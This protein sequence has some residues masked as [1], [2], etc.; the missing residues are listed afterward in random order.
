MAVPGLR[1]EGAGRLTVDGARYLLV[2]PETLAAAQK[3]VEEAL[4]PAAAECLARGGRAGGARAAAP[5][6]GDADARVRRL[7]AIGAEI[8]WG[9][10]ALER[11]DG[12]DL[13]VSVAGSPFAEAY[14]PAPGPVCHLVRG[15]LESLAAAVLARPRP[16][17]EEACVAA[18]AARCRFRTVPA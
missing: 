8:G 5:L 17:V 2:R 3:A 15:V 7:L 16:I 18:G 9:E 11:L 12:D 13:V 4:G 10:F 6:A 1:R 14:G